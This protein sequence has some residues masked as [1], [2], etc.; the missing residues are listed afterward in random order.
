MRHKKLA[1][2]LAISVLWLATPFLSVPRANAFHDGLSVELTGTMIKGTDKFFDTI[3]TAARE[4]SIVTFN[5]KI[6]MSS[7][8]GQRNLTI[9]V[10]FDWMT[11]W[12]NASNANPASTLAATKDQYVT[13]TVSVTMPTLTGQFAGYNLYLHD[14]VLQVWSNKTNTPI[15][16][17]TC[18]GDIAGAPLAGCVPFFGGD[19]AIYSTVQADGIALREEAENKIDHLTS[20]L[21]IPFGFASP[22]GW[23]KATA[24]VSQADAELGLGDSYYDVGDF[25][26]AKT[27]YQN[28]LNLANSAASGLGGGE[29]ANYAGALMTST[30]WLLGGVAAILLGLG[31]FMYL[32]GRSK[33]SA[34]RN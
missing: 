33:T 6:M 19:F 24:D 10:K 29:S 16:K 26:S 4:G 23:S 17:D 31:G 11:G 28:A 25:A 13:A 22:P 30:G 7:L 12:V 1:T 20:R 8:A 3:V 18:I 9:G 15:T 2:L 27:H 5:A 21:T 14:W 32:R 34:L